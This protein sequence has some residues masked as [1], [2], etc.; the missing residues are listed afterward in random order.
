[1]PVRIDNAKNRKTDIYGYN[2]ASLSAVLFQALF[3]INK[4]I[5]TAAVMNNSLPFWT[6]SAKSDGDPVLAF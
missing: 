3:H 5:N 2:S 4:K 6:I 1:M